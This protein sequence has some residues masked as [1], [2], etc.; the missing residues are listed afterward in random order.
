MVGVVEVVQAGTDPN[1]PRLVDF[2]STVRTL[3]APVNPHM[4][5][6]F[7]GQDPPEPPAVAR[8]LRRL[9][10]A[11]GLDATRVLPFRPYSALSARRVGDTREWGRDR[12][13]DRQVLVILERVHASATQRAAQLQP[14]PP[15]PPETDHPR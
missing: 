5:V 12:A 9:A 2:H 15:S 7:L 13:L 1:G 4:A 10:N 6:A 8:T 3:A 11:L 14:Q